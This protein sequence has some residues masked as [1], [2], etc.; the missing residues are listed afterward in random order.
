MPS[1]I[2]VANCRKGTSPKNSKYEFSPSWCSSVTEYQDG[3]KSY[4]EFFGLLPFLLQKNTKMAK[5]ILWIFGFV[6]FLQLE[7][8]IYTYTHQFVS[9]I[10]PVLM[11]KT[12][13]ETSDFL[14][15]DVANRQ[16]RLHW[17]TMTTSHVCHHDLRFQNPYN[18]KT[19]LHINYGVTLEVTEYYKSLK[20][21]IHHFNILSFNTRCGHYA[22][23][24]DACTVSHVWRSICSVYTDIDLELRITGRMNASRWLILSAVFKCN[25]HRT[26]DLDRSIVYSTRHTRVERR[27]PDCNFE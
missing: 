20:S 11:M 8:H 14:R 10:T 4:C 12:I 16:R 27:K 2:W 3:E 24:C 17:V 22:T 9:L 18:T 5:L 15:I 1:L 26:S 21:G 6:S 13:S 25:M 19:P 7:I 23:K